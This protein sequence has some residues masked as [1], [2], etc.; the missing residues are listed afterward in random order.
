MS[1]YNSSAPNKFFA[2]NICA[3]HVGKGII[4]SVAHNLRQLERLPPIL[5]DHFY[6][7]ELL[8][9]FNPADIPQ[10]EQAYSLIPGTNQRVAKGL[11][12]QTVEQLAK[13]LDD[14]KVDRRYS[15]LYSEN[16]CKPFL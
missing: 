11:N 2:N 13:K 12:Q 5:S 4:V 10:F 3:F 6:Q 1:V 9:K 8:S 15:K 16:C 7:T 14:A